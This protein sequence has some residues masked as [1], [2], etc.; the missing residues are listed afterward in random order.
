MIQK[1]RRPK[2]VFSYI[3]RNGDMIASTEMAM[4]AFHAHDDD[5]LF[6]IQHPAESPS[7]DSAN[8]FVERTV[9]RIRNGRKSPYQV[10]PV[11]MPF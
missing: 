9:R 6:Q 10:P 2:P 5:F 4:P 11:G 7:S 8:V 3:P 1:I